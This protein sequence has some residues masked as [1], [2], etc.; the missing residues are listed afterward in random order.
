[1]V[2][3]QTMYRPSRGLSGKKIFDHCTYSKHTILPIT[4]VPPREYG[5]FI[6]SSGGVVFLFAFHQLNGGTYCHHSPFNLNCCPPHL[7]VLFHQGGPELNPGIEK[8]S[9]QYQ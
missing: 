7:L 6:E 8:A 5:S 9:L 2:W 1:M 4:S 3:A